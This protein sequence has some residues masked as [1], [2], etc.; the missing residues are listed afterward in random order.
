MILEGV[1]GSI[2]LV[3][4]VGVGELELF[5]S[6]DPGAAGGGIVIST[7]EGVS[8]TP[9]CCGVQLPPITGVPDR[10]F[11]RL[12]APVIVGVEVADIDTFFGPLLV[13]PMVGRVIGECRVA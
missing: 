3:V 8:M 6:P 4:I 2:S 1:T 11:R 7:G 12:L 5:D 13:P 10:L 9:C